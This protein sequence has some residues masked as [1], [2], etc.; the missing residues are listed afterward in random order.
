MLAVSVEGRSWRWGKKVPETIWSGDEMA[1]R[2][3]PDVVVS[4]KMASDSLTCVVSCFTSALS[5]SFDLDSS[6]SR[7]LSRYRCS[8][9]PSFSSR[10]SQTKV[11][12]TRISPSF[13]PTL[14]HSLPL[15]C[16]LP[17][18]FVDCSS[19]APIFSNRSLQVVPTPLSSK[20]R[21]FERSGKRP[22]A[23]GDLSLLLRRARD[24]EQRLPRDFLNRS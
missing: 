8:A 10:N 4:L 19:S 14:R 7:F 22:L 13:L 15:Q 11:S 1:L 17:T 12:Y 16:S 2:P 20:R 6:C 3:D 21:S 18:S 23:G 5:L 24:L 9:F